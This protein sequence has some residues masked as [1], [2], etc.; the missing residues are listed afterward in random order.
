MPSSRLND[1]ATPPEG[2]W[3]ELTATARRAWPGIDVEPA[4]FAR[5]LARHLPSGQPPAE[6]SAALHLADLYLACACVARAPAALERLAQLL[7]DEVKAAVKRLDPSPAFADEIRQLLWEKLL[8]AGDEPKLSAYSGRGP[9]A[10]WLR[11]AA[12]RAALDLR[13]SAK[14]VPSESVET[15]AAAGSDPELAL[16]RARDGAAVKQAFADAFGLLTSRERNLLRMHLFEGLS[17]SQIG[18]H[19]GAHRATVARWLDAAR[20]RLLDEI[21]R[22]LSERLRLGRAEF[23]SLVGQL[24]SRLDLSI[25]AFLL[26]SHE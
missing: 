19:Y 16:L 15:V 14:E 8:L 11:A 25:S 20:Q 1:G 5:H 12:L 26:R 10:S 4:Q 2:A 9:L 6:A 17:H 22:L 13:R 24:R 18:A 3:E 21:R 7:S 23:E